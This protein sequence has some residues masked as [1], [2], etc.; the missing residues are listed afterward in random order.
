MPTCTS[1]QI[2]FHAIRHCIL[3]LP[4]SNRILPAS[5][6]LTAIAQ[7]IREIKVLREHRQTNLTAV[8]G[9]E[10]KQS[11]LRTPWIRGYII[12]SLPAYPFPHTGAKS[13]VDNSRHALSFTRVPNSLTAKIKSAKI[14]SAKISETRILAGFA[15]ICTRENDH[16]LNP[17]RSV[18]DHLQFQK[19]DG[20]KAW[21]R[22]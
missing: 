14:K 20:R 19:L 22:G 10:R 4:N 5:V 1:E 9:R 18:F 6:P 3:R 17:H 12:L 2:A 11:L 21:E 7:A 15:K 16:G 8:Q 13:S